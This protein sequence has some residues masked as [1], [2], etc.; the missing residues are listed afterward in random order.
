MPSGNNYITRPYRSS[1]LLSVS[2]I[3]ASGTA[4]FESELWPGEGIPVFAATTVR[5]SVYEEPTT[6]AKRLN[7]LK[8]RWADYFL[9]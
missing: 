9:R 8:T 3:Q 5:L 2:L 7:D 1:S 4:I 6:F